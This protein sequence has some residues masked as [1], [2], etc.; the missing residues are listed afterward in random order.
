V[1]VPK[2]IYWLAA[3]F[4]DRRKPLNFWLGVE[5]ENE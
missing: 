2:L 5:K 4:G 1:L 3:F